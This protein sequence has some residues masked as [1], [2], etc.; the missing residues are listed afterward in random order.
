MKNK[1][2]KIIVKCNL[3]N[4]LSLPIIMFRIFPIKK[5]RIMFEN[6]TGKGYG[7]SPKYIAEKLLKSDKEYDLYW[8]VRKGTKIDFP[9]GIKPIKLYSFLYFYILATSK[10]WIANSRFDQYVIKRKKQTYIQTWHGCLALKK[11]EYDA[12]N[13]LSDYYKKVMKK[14]NR[15]IDYMISNS[16]FCT[17]M[18]R[19]GF[20]YDGEILEYGT[21]RNDVFYDKTNELSK[22]IKKQLGIDSKLSILLYAPTFRNDCEYNPY[23]VD[24]DSLIEALELKTKKKWIVLVKLHPRITD[25]SKFFTFKKNVIDVTPYSDIQ[26]LICV[27]DIL[28]TDYSS[29]MFE[30]MI[31]N[32]TVIIYASDIDKYNE[33]RGYYFSFKELPFPLIENNEDLIKY[34]NNFNFNDMVKEYK[35]FK[36][37]VGL[38]ENG[39]ASEKVCELI[40]HILCGEKD[41]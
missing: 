38:A 32:K 22:Q 35:G 17:K 26:E 11:I 2:K 15:N 7:D 3:V 40:D 13:K 14:D 21:P 16:K 41:G 1:I 36:Q 29:T 37:E 23:D 20:R 39:I 27:C 9:L 10:I 33:E 31:A 4:I 19:N 8:V 34:V 24:F 25:S 18:Y 12:E 30:A 6:F 5:N 28:M